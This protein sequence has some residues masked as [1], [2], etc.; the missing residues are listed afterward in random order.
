LRGYRSWLK[1]PPVSSG[2]FKDGEFILLK[3]MTKDKNNRDKII[4]KL[5][6]TRENLLDE[7]NSIKSPSKD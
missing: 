2:N 6:V 3:V 5:V 1:F 7:I 4:Y